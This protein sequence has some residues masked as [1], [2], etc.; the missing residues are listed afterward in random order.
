MD[1]GCGLSSQAAAFQV[2]SPEFKLQPNKEKKRKERN[3]PYLHQLIGNT[4]LPASSVTLG[5]HDWDI[6]DQELW[7]RSLRTDLSEWAKRTQ[8]F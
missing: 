1:W 4:D 7:G 6:G 8:P 3:L 5:D 2:Q